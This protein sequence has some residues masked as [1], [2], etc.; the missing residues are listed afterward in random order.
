M[1][2]I[3]ISRKQALL[4]IG[5]AGAAI[6]GIQQEAREENKTLTKDQLLRAAK[7]MHFAVEEVSRQGIDKESTVENLLELAEF[8][9]QAMKEQ[10]A[11]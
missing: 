8:L 2:D 11:E 1:S 9:V 5:A 7:F 10:P 6:S 3:T 4:A